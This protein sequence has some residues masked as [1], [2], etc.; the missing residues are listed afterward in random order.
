MVRR[1]RWHVVGHDA[2]AVVCRDL[3][4]DQLVRFRLVA[5]LAEILVAHGHDFTA[6]YGLVK[7]ERLA[8]LATEVEV[9][10]SADSGWFH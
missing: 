5:H 9:G 10:D 1:G 8:R 6:K 2:E 3:T 7:M 4:P